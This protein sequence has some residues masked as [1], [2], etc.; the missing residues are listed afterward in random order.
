MA[1]RNEPFVTKP[2]AVDATIRVLSSLADIPRADW[3][4]CANPGWDS[5]GVQA[6]LPPGCKEPPTQTV[7]YNP[8]ISHDF[9]WSLE[10][11]GAAVRKTGWLAQHL[12]LAGADGRPAGVMPAYLKSHSMGEY[13][14]DHGW[15]E[16]FERA[17]GRYYPKLQAGVPFTPVPGRRLLVKPGAD[18]GLRR[19]TLAAGAVALARRLAVSSLHA[20]FLTEADQDVLAEQGFLRRTDQQFHF[21]NEG[22]GSFE[23]FLAVLSSRHRKT[24]RRER[25]DALA[26][27]VEVVQLT[28]KDLTE[29]AWDAFF[30]FYMDTGNRKWGRPYLNRKFFS[31]IGERMADRILLILATRNGKPIA[32]ALNFIGSD[33]LYG[34]YWGALEEQPF[35]HFELCYYQAMDWAIAH[36][37]PRVEAG[38]QG[39]HKVARGYRPTTT[40]SAHWIADASF[41][42]AVSDYLERERRQ[43]AADETALAA[44]L[45]FREANPESGE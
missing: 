40:Y 6:Q 41:R 11:S 26:G 14:F 15:A 19:S 33:T 7:A 29:A 10:E 2:Q 34:R 1:L 17:G 31:L 12:I 44:Y 37:L 18:S 36:R 43:V 9:L 30:A 25:R 3:D 23:D 24:V 4:A 16:A 39:E 28:G 45:P 5:S 27:G 21:L 13:V 35:L 22:Y 42:R 32:G 20:T 8:F 38:A